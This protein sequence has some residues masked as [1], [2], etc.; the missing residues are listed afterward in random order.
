MM[1]IYWFNFDERDKLARVKDYLRP[2]AL[3]PPWCRLPHTVP[4][5]LPPPPLPTPYTYA[6]VR[7]FG[8]AHPLL[9]PLLV[10]PDAA[11][12]YRGS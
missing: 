2:L 11:A 3:L 4:L 6:P 5:A 12:P 9:L 10:S 1:M 7:G 8:I